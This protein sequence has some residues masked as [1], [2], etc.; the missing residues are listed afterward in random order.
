MNQ[1][2]IYQDIL[3]LARETERYKTL[4]FCIDLVQIVLEDQPGRMKLLTDAMFKYAEKEGEE[5]GQC[6]KGPSHE[7]GSKLSV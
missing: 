3:K 1:E 7:A 6:E 5:S 2:E 4:C